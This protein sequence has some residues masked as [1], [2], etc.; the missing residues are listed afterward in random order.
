MQG[1]KEAV[2]DLQGKHQLKRDVLSTEDT[3]ME[4]RGQE[5]EGVADDKDEPGT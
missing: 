2:E 5:G 3:Q 1:L 4:T